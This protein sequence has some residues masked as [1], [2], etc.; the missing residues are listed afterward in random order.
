MKKPMMN[1]L[2]QRMAG[3]GMIQQDAKA[4]TYYTAVLNRIS[5]EGELSISWVENLLNPHPKADFM[6][7][8]KRVELV[9]EWIETTLTDPELSKD[10]VLVMELQDIKNAMLRSLHELSMHH[11]LS[12]AG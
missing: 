9:N 1:V 8:R 7:W 5:Q 6:E 12:S 2:F 11:A 10:R 4:M 3:I